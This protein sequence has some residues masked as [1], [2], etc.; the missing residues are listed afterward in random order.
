VAT[1]NYIG[2]HIQKNKIRKKKCIKRKSKIYE[3]KK[4]SKML[5]TDLMTFNKI[6]KQGLKQI[7]HEKNLKKSIQEKKQIEE[8]RRKIKLKMKIEK[9]MK[10]FLPDI[11][12]NISKNTKSKAKR[13]V[14]SLTQEEHE[15]VEKEKEDQVLDYV[16]NLNFD[17]FIEEVEVI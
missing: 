2:Y 10:K 14:W 6:N 7:L 4:P 11:D 16:D 1:Q 13:A 12:L 3:L 5:T 8:K 9:M 15:Q 17:N